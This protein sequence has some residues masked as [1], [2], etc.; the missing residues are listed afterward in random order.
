MNKKATSV[1]IRRIIIG[2]FLFAIGLC[3]SFYSF[4]S[5]DRWPHSIQWFVSYY[6]KGDPLCMIL[7]IFLLMFGC[8]VLAKGIIEYIINPFRENKP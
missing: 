5:I 3:L 1:S 4:A 2:C 8:V 7:S 6:I